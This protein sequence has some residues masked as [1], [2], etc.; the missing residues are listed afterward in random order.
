MTPHAAETAAR[1]RTLADLVERGA[2]VDCAVRWAAGSPAEIVAH[3]AR[4]A[5]VSAG[6]TDPI[7][8]RG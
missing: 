7:P 4:G 8:T 5:T 1:L 2:V 3:D 6:P